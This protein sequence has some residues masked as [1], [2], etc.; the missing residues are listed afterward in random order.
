V[1]IIIIVSILGGLGNQ[2]FQ[3]AAARRLS[4]LKNVNF[5]LDITAFN[6][7]KLREYSL[8]HY[9]I[10]ENIAT[11]TEIEYYTR[12]RKFNKFY[13]CIPKLKPN[14]IPIMFKEKHFSYNQEI[15]KIPNNIYLSGYWQNEKYFKDIEPIIRKEFKLKSISSEQSLK[16]ADKIQNCNAVNLHIRRGD[17][18]SD[19]TTNQFH[20]VCSLEYYYMAIQKLSI[21]IEELHF[22]IFS[23]DIPWVRE[24]LKIN[25]PTTYVSHNGTER[26]YEDLWLMSL[27][28]HHI[29]ANSSFSWWGAWLAENSKKIVIAPQRWFNNPSIDTSDLLPLS[30]I[31][32]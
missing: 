18:I 28:K 9:N 1:I 3:Y 8:N 15:V 27:C 2:L 31:K 4:E 17:Y 22:F 6:E 12:K 13:K 21:K 29:I 11:P 7:Y 25:F 32:L 24:N 20:G 14:N 26:D 16:M 10:I 23:D 5:K 19:Q 30:W